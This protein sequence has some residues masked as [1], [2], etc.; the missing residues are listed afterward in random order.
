MKPIITID[1]IFDAFLRA[2]KKVAI[3]AASVC[4]IGCIFQ[5][6]EMDYYLGDDTPQ[7]ANAIAA[8]LIMEDKYDLLVVYNGNYDTVMHHCGPESL[9]SLSE[10]RANSEAF[11]T[12]AEMIQQ[13]WK[14]H[15]TLMAFAMDHGCHVKPNGHGDHGTDSPLDLN[16]CHSYRFFE[17]T[18]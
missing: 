17:A 7:A 4:S 12:F 11:A 8:H 5:G 9:E 14:S 6:R 13:H 2:G 18:E 1:T 10:A 3:V 15:N 16:I